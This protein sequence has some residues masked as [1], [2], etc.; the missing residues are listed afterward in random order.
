[1]KGVGQASYRLDSGKP[2]KMKDVFYV[3]GLRKNLLSILALDE[4]GFKVAFIDGEVLMWPRGKSI[5]D[6][7]VI[8]VQEG[9]LY[10]LKRLSVSTLVHN[11]VTPSE[12][13]HR[14]FAQIHYKALLIMSKMV[15]SLPEIQVDHEGICKGCAQGKNVKKP[16]P[17]SDNKSKGALDIIHSDVCTPGLLQRNYGTQ[18]AT[19]EKTYVHQVIATLV[20]KSGMG[21]SS[22]KVR[23]VELPLLE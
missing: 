15:T 22:E 20:K 19:P 21:Y 7:V 16:F 14:R 10:K 9:S 4:K 12:L 2:M 3:H 18:R 13:W 1:M 17:S 8:D 6:A 5:D 23:Y 11:T